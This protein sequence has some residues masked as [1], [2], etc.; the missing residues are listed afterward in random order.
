VLK[1]YN[2]WGEKV[3]ETN[4]IAN[5]WDGKSR[6]MGSPHGVYFWVA[7]W[8]LSSDNKTEDTIQSG[9]IELLR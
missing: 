4:E 5:F 8:N 3:F 2:R 9:L 6:G 1:I 7:S